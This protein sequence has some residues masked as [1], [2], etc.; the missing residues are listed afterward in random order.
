MRAALAR[1]I[2]ILAD[3]SGWETT[4]A[5]FRRPWI[6]WARRSSP[7]SGSSSGVT[8]SLV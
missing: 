3:F 2:P 1:G 6:L 8:P 4:R 7:P 5:A